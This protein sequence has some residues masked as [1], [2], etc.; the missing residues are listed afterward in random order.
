MKATVDNL[1]GSVETLSPKESVE[2]ANTVLRA[3]VR[4]LEGFSEDKPEAS[5]PRG[6]SPLGFEAILV[7]EELLKSFPCAKLP[8]ICMVEACQNMT[9][10]EK[11]LIRETLNLLTCA[12]S[13]THTQTNRNRQKGI[14]NQI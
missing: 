1:R 5:K 12:D 4:T 11:S 2:G 14:T 9:E 7:P 8:R 13:S 6:H 10:T 3:I